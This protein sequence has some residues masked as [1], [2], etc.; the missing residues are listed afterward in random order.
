MS[1][2]TC[3]TLCLGFATN[4]SSEVLAPEA[5]YGAIAAEQHGLVTGTQL[6]ALGL[7]PG[8]IHRRVRAGC[9]LKV[10]PGVFRL[11]AVPRSWHQRAMAV[12]LWAG[13][14][15]AIGGTAAAAMHGLDGCPLPSA[16]TVVTRRS[17][18]SPSRLVIVRRPQDFD[19]RE[20]VTIAGIGVTNCT[21]TLIDLAPL[22]S[23]A[24]LELAVEDARRRRVVT[25]AALE[26]LLARAPANQ[27]GRR[28][29][30]TVLSRI[31]GTTPTDSGLEVKVVRLLRRGGFPEPVRQEILTDEGEFAGRVDLVYPERKLV[32]EVQSHR[33]HDGRRHIDDDSA[34]H[35]RHHAMGWIVMK[36]TSKMLM[37]NAR[38]AFL[39]DLRRAY[40]RATPS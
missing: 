40:D 36:A 7:S 12:Y 4:M 23:N 9:L 6:R 37:G 14:D 38:A 25:P 30:L 11:A 2:A 1:S 29:L 22:V 13:P 24:Q 21:R 33:W 8:A 26:Q 5:A 31:S 27:A 18:K 3:D 15:S 20:K 39:R 28:K 16:I 10:L 19:P 32:I 17:L 35:N 34:R